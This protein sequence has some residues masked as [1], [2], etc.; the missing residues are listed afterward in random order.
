MASQDRGQPS[1]VTAT[2][3]Q[4]VWLGSHG[5]S[6]EQRFHKGMLGYSVERFGK[7]VIDLLGA[8]FGLVVLSPLFVLVGAAIRLESSG[9]AFFKQ[10]RIGKDGQPFTFYKFRTMKNGNNSKIHQEYVRRLI[11]DGSEE[12]K[13]ETGSFKLGADPRITRLGHFLRHTSIDELPQLINVLTG[14]MSLVGPRPPLPYEVEVY[15]EHAFRRLEET[16]GMTGLWQVSG[17]A[18]TTFDEMVELDVKYIDNWSLG[19][20]VSILA[21]TIPAVFGGKG[22]W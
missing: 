8:V 21:R 6:A 16:P 1:A 18:D 19:L 11:T 13:G 5:A 22:A 7:R 9:P 15:P 14:E 4:P 10:E 20:D 3:G 17:R 2:A 12:L